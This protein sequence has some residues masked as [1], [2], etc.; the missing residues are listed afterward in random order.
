MKNVS[1]ANVTITFSGFDVDSDTVDIDINVKGQSF[2]VEVQTFR[3]NPNDLVIDS[4]QPD[5]LALA[6]AMKVSPTLLGIA[7]E[8]SATLQALV[9]KE[10]AEAYAASYE[11]EAIHAQGATSDYTTYAERVHSVHDDIKYCFIADASTIFVRTTMSE[12]RFN[13]MPDTVTIDDDEVLE[14]IEA[15]IQ[16][17][18]EDPLALFDELYAKANAP[19]AA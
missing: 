7:L 13:N 11:A 6:A 17:C 3:S 18:A 2:C 4:I 12:L 5:F 10:T 15:A 14:R 16:D 1:L 19:V 9:V 8:H